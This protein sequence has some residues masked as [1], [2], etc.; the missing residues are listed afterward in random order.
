[1]HIFLEFDTLMKYLYTKTL[2]MEQREKI[3]NRENLNSLQVAQMKMEY[4]I[5]K[6]IV[7]K[8]KYIYYYYHFF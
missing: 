4:C 6:Q 8:T 2:V 1:M 7:L 3:I 5:A